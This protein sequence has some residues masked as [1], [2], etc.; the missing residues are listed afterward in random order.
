MRREIYGWKKMLVLFYDWEWVRRVIGGK[1]EQW[2]CVYEGTPMWAPVDR[3][4]VKG[5]KTK[6][7]DDGASVLDKQVCP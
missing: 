3:W 1:W 7:F 5:D 4:S 2:L 6:I